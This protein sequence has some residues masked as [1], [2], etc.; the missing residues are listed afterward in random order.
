MKKYCFIILIAIISVFAS[1]S[2]EETAI[3]TGDGIQENFLKS[4][5][6]EIFSEDNQSS[7]LVVISSNDAES[8]EDAKN[9]LILITDLN[10][11]KNLVVKKDEKQVETP[12]NSGIEV[13]L[14]IL[15][16]NTSLK[17]IGIG[18]KGNSFKDGN[19]P[20]AHTYTY[21]CIESDWFLNVRFNYNSQSAK[22]ILVKMGH[23][24]CW[25][26]GWNYPDSEWTHYFE[27]AHH[28]LIVSN[29]WNGQND[30]YKLGARVV[31]DLSENQN[32]TIILSSTEL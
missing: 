14:D 6:I 22:G 5:T 21:T 26:C 9:S 32:Y 11:T 31:T 15:K 25:L 16:I 29:P 20:S 12:V 13:Q 30:I 27:S 3:Q 1:C 23:L 2:K 4:D 10:V 24:D 18:A 28:H 8:F 17:T 19:L 7:A